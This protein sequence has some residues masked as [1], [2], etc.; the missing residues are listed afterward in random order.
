M[1]SNQ[2]WDLPLTRLQAARALHWADRPSLQCRPSCVAAAVGSFRAF[3]PT[4]RVPRQRTLGCTDGACPSCDGSDTTRSVEAVAWL[5]SE[6]SP[7]GTAESRWHR[8]T[9]VYR[10]GN[11]LLGAVIG[12]LFLATGPLVATSC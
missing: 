12:V 3:D 5:A 4:R 1:F 11:R 7:R 10:K 8:N 6:S 2:E 9:V